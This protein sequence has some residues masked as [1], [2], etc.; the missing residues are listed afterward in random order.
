[1]DCA[2]VVVFRSDRDLERLPFDLGIGA[3]ISMT[4]DGISLTVR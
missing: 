4:F 1:L 2:V 3:L